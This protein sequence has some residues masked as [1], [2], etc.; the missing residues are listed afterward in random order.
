MRRNRNTSSPSRLIPGSQLKAVRNPKS[1]M[2][3]RTNSLTAGWISPRI[4]P[5]LPSKSRDP[6]EALRQSFGSRITLACRL[7]RLCTRF[8][9]EQRFPRCFAAGVSDGGRVEAPQIGGRSRDQAARRRLLA[10]MGRRIRNIPN[11]WCGS[12]L[13]PGIFS[14][15]R[16]C[17]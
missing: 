3:Q 4:R 8:S 2:T 1:A 13:S 7:F 12:R 6:A 16:S 17:D 15:S 11:R 9:G 5:A 14:E 10:K